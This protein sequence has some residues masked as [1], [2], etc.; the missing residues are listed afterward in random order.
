MI[1]ALNQCAESHK[2]DSQGDGLNAA[3]GGDGAG[4][5]EHEEH[6]QQQRCRSQFADW[7]GIESRSSGRNRL[8][9]RT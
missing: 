7:Q 6:N 5:H 1:P 2:H 4:P 9:E 8:K 3:T